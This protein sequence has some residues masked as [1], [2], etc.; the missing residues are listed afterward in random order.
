MSSTCC[1]KHLQ[2]ATSG[3]VL[4]RSALRSQRYPPSRRCLLCHPLTSP[5]AA[6]PTSVQLL[7]SCGNESNET[8]HT[9]VS[10][11]NHRLFFFQ[12]A[13]PPMIG[14]QRQTAYGRQA[15]ASWAL[16]LDKPPILRSL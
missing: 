1:K 2:R 14:G 4:C 10:G 8:R 6:V 16:V 7:S 11:Q 3:L 5:Q 12:T 15:L 13:G 9:T